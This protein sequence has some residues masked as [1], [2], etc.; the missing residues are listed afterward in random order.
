MSMFHA[1]KLSQL[2]RFVHWIGCFLGTALALLFTTF[3][4]AEGPPPLSDG[5]IA[6]TVTAIGFLLSWWR[7]LLGGLMSMAGIGG[8]YLWHLTETGN[9]PGGWVFPLCFIPVIL[10]VISSLLRRSTEW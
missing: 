10:L 9:F 4:I 2:P 3:T 7:D 8:F 1:T 5:S 6:L